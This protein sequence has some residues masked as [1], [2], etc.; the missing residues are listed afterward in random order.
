MIRGT[1]KIQKY[2]ELQ[3][4]TVGIHLAVIRL[5]EHQADVVISL[6]FLLHAHPQSSSAGME[7]VSGCDVDLVEVC[8]GFKIVDPGLFALGTMPSN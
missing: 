7:H 2:N 1:Q 3:T 8:K 6:N 5:P 4:N